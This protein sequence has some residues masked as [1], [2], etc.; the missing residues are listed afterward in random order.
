CARSIVSGSG[1]TGFSCRA[2]SRRR[3]RR[4]RARG[5]RRGFIAEQVGGDRE[6][7][8]SL[9][10]DRLLLPHGAEER[11]L[12]DLF[13]PVAVPQPSRQVAHERLV[14]LAK[15]AIEISHTVTTLGRWSLASKR[16][17]RSR[18]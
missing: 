6:Q 9:T 16:R 3:L 5:A 15:E 10:H 8:A 17:F 1:S 11:L 13:R 2:C 18:P 7:P 14:V 12:G 4:L